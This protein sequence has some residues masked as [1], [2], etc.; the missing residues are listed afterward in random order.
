MAMQSNG[1]MTDYLCSAWMDHFILRRL[2]LGKMNPSTHCHLMILDSHNSPVTVE[3][4]KKATEARLVLI[5]Y[6]S[7]HKLLMPSN[8]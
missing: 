1:W 7:T 3:V 2:V 8:H 6:V 5:Y 4:V